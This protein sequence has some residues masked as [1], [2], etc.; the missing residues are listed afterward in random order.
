MEKREVMFYVVI[1]VVFLLFLYVAF[2]FLSKTTIL[3]PRTLIGNI[4]LDLQENYKTGDKLTG[5]IFMSKKSRDSMDSSGF[6]LLTKGNES[7]FSET[8]FL[9]DI[10]IKDMDSEDYFVEL[11]QIKDF[12]FQEPG[13]YEIFFSVMDL[14]L[15]IKKSF[16]V[17]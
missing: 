2:S 11:N 6:L 14:N 16:K 12:T 15:N 1:S 5:K 4:V 17:K 8:F 9:K 7:I 13:E 3:N 10:L